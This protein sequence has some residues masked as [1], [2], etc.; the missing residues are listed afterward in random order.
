MSKKKL[1]EDLMKSVSPPDFANQEH[2]TVLRE[3][4]LNQSAGG[5]E[6]ARGEGFIMKVFKKAG[7]NRFA[8]GSA[9]GLA[10][11][12]AVVL[13][14]LTLSSPGEVFA[15]AMDAMSEFPV[16]HYQ[17][18]KRAI[19]NSWGPVVDPRNPI[20]ANDE[21]WAHRDDQGRVLAV[22]YESGL[23]TGDRFIRLISDGT[24]LTC[25]PAINWAERRTG[26]PEEWLQVGLVSILQHAADLD[27]EKLTIEEADDQVVARA[28]V[29]AVTST[30]NSP[31]PT[32]LSAF[33]TRQTFV[34]D[35]DSGLLRSLL[36]EG[37]WEGEYIPLV[38]I[39]NVEYLDYDPELFRL[40]LPEDV[41]WSD[42][43]LENG[44]RPA[45][46][47][48][49]ALPEEAARAF[50]EA[51]IAE[52]Y[53]TMELYCSGFP[54][55][56]LLKQ[57]RSVGLA[58]VA[59]VLLGEAHRDRESTYPGLY[60]PYE[61]LMEDGQVKKHRIALKPFDDESGWY[62]DGGI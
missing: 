28:E 40:D 54:Y 29:K 17:L 55:P 5:S 60:V 6:D 59:L 39:E 1:A 26:Q 46:Q 47:E 32:H 2:M 57:A 37:D 12:V 16:V 19:P 44:A 52:D 9:V 24:V 27:E 14:V 13:V 25:K 18:H 48:K 35:A 56:A 22:R 10:T 61:L 7:E 43:S 62:V 38:R 41:L 42:G 53:Q 34:F 8:M 4:L 11:A 33:D 58:P 50:F 31:V 3:R 45:G 21:V 51:W 36:I 15:R 30:G 23:V 49:A 20:L